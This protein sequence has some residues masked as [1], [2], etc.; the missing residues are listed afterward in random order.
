LIRERTAVFRVAVFVTV[1]GLSMGAALPASGAEVTVF[2]AASLKEAMDEQTRRFEAATGNKVIVSYGGS[3]ALARQI[4]AGAP[5]DV[6]IS[7]DLDWVDYVER[8]GLLVSGSRVNLLRNE[9]V[10]IAP[11]TSSAAL[12]IAPGF[13]LAT[14]LR[15]EKL[16]MAN[17]DSVPAG[18]YGKRALESLGVWKSVEKQVVRTDNVRAALVLVARGEATFGIVYKTDALA[19]RSVR[20]VDTFPEATHAPIVYPAAL[21]APGGSPAAKALLD[22]LR[23]GAARPIWEKYGFA[24]L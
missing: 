15:N 4:E 3:N 17:P 1:L 8:R 2:A 20:I 6:F 9:L 16:A 13:A 10:L 22:F 12:R 24:P 18:K 23:S 5:A 11:A 14:A 19:E 7:A 21:V